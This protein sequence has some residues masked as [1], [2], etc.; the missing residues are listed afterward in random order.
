MGWG[1]TGRA[2][3]P[4]VS[5]LILGFLQSLT[6]APGVDGDPSSAGMGQMGVDGVTPELGLPG[7]GQHVRRV[8]QESTGLKLKF[9]IN[10]K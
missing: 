9:R 6:S 1:E 7:T 4:E 10:N 2:A 8:N 3:S 5:L